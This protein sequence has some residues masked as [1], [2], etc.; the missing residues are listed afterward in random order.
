MIADEVK[1][2]GANA[3]ATT[4]H[5]REEAVA[6]LFCA[7]N[8]SAKGDICTVVDYAAERIIIDQ[9]RTAMLGETIDKHF[10]E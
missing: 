4:L 5:M 2:Q 1:S 3:L 7:T 6:Q 8:L 10:D 9:I